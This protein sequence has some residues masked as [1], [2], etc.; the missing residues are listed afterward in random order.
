M[1]CPLNNK[2]Y[3]LNQTKDSHASAASLQIYVM[4]KQRERNENNSYIWYI[5]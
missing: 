2:A 3:E 4:E 1:E 5:Q